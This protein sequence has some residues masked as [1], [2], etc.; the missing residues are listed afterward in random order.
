[1]LERIKKVVEFDQELDAKAREIL[2]SLEV[3]I[4]LKFSLLLNSLLDGGRN[5]LQ[6]LNGLVELV[7]LPEQLRL[8]VTLADALRFPQSKHVHVKGS[9]GLFLASLC[10]VPDRVRLLKF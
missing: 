2:D 6:R 4:R 9:Q 7:L 8:V 3:F 5:S 1:M 10:I